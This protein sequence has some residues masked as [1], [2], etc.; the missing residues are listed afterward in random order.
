MKRP[1]RAQLKEAAKLI[2]ECAANGLGNPTGVE[3]AKRDLQTARQALDAGEPTKAR[4]SF[5][6]AMDY[7]S[8]MA[9]EGM[10]RVRE[11]LDK[12]I[13][14]PTGRWNDEQQ[15]LL[16][17][18]REKLRGLEQ[19]RKL[20][21]KKARKDRDAQSE[22]YREVEW[23]YTLMELTKQEQEAGEPP[24]LHVQVWRRRPA[25]S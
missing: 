6:A 15:R 21:R 3:M 11:I 10:P 24:S 13:G 5:T 12:R 8:G 1:S 23:A 22:H 17:K 19:Q 9:M 25:R 20:E 16:G 4:E 14:K 18:T 2:D 7:L